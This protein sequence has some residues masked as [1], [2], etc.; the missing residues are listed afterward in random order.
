M[1]TSQVSCNILFIG[2]GGV[3]KTSWVNQFHTNRSDSCDPN[4]VSFQLGRNM[5]VSLKFHCKSDISNE[6]LENEALQTYDGIIFMGDIT[7]PESFSIPLLCDLIKKY[8]NIPLLKC[9]NKADVKFE[10]AHSVTETLLYFNQGFRLTSSENLMGWPDM[11]EFLYT[12][13]KKKM[14]PPRRSS[15]IKNQLTDGYDVDV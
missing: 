11:Y 12:I 15:R 1:T 14:Q 5:Y 7:R 6:D 2:A 10:T 4:T 8:E 9:A 13:C 3:G